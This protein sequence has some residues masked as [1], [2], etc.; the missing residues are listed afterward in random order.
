MSLTGNQAAWAGT[1]PGENGKI[2]FTSN[3]DGNAEIYV[4][5]PDGT[6]QTRL[7]N[8]AASDFEPSWSPDGT[9]IIFTSERDGNREIYVMNADGSAQTRLTNNPTEDASPSWSPDGTKIAFFSNRGGS[10]G[11]FIMNAADG[12]GQ[13]RLTN[14]T[15]SDS[16]PDFG[17]LSPSSAIEALIE[18]IKD[19]GLSRSTETSL[20]APLSQ[21]VN[22]LNDGNPNNDSA[23]CGKLTAFIIQVNTMEHQGNLT[24]QQA[25]ELRTEANDI[26]NSLG[27]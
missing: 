4:M 23:A 20:I 2:A 25:N 12:T 9:K 19:M 14:N 24:T 8:N 3:R 6:G 1:F 7:T 17:P 5:N 13:T 11:I 16:Q 26:K 22:L 10:D 27:C 18:E 15:A 21:A